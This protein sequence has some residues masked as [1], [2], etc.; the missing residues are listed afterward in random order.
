MDKLLSLLL[1]ESIPAFT[2]AKFHAL[3]MML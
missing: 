3:R 2:V 1:V